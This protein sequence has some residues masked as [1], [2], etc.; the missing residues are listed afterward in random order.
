M[1]RFLLFDSEC[2]LCTDLASA[3]EHESGGWLIARSLRNPDMRAL[4]DQERPGWRWE[5]TLLEVK[6]DQVRVFTGLAMRAR[7]LA[8]LGLKRSWRV[9][10]LV[11]RAV[12]PSS[13]HLERRHFL[14][15]AGMLLGGFVLLGVPTKWWPGQESRHDALSSVA[16][17]QGEEYAGFLL[18]PEGVPAPSSVRDYKYG[19]PTMCGVNDDKATYAYQQHPDAV[20]IDLVS[21]RD[22]AVQGGFPVYTL[23]KLSPALSLRPSGASLIKHGTGELF[24]GWVTFEAYSQKAEIWYTAA[25]ILAQVDFPRPVP[26]WYSKPVEPNGPAVIL[27]KVDFLPSGLGI[28]VRT[29]VGFTLHWIHLD[30]Y[31]TLSVEHLPD[32]E[33][34]A[35][36]SALTLII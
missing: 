17:S 30:V 4:L 28:L 22:L 2:A 29:L 12:M 20:H 14:Q 34:Q 9:A 25:S 33:P 15:Q 24:G 1:E 26:L 21:A 16:P 31:Y 27:E 5:P 10:Q 23:G 32:A 6:G 36:A 7:L 11:S 19:I 18:L 35:F 13:I 3:I 8:G